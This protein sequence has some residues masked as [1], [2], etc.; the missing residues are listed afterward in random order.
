MIVYDKNL[1]DGKL[2]DQGT[3]RIVDGKLEFKITSKETEWIIKNSCMYTPDIDPKV[4]ISRL[5]WLSM[6]STIH[7][8][9]EDGE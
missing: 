9:K 3:I 4:F 8:H 5:A 1:A 7:I 6:S 2:T